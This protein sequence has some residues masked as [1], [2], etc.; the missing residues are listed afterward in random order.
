MTGSEVVAEVGIASGSNLG[1][2]GPETTVVVVASDLE[3]EAPIWW[4]RTKGASDRGAK[5]IVLNARSTKLDN[6][7]ACT[8]Q[9]EYGDAVGAVNNLLGALKSAKALDDDFGKNR[10]EG[11]NDV[12]GAKYGTIPAPFKE[13][14]EILA[15]TENLIVFVGAEGME[16][17]EH[18]DLMQAAGNLL[19]ATGRV[20]R[21]NNGLIPVWPGANTQG[22]LDMGFRAE[23]TAQALKQKVVI[24]AGADIDPADLQDAEFVIAVSLFPSATTEAADVVLPRQ[25]VPERRTAAKGRDSEQDLF[26][27]EN[28]LGR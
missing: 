5:I 19:G 10:S 8:L 26:L 15:G 4:L 22:A 6:Y 25:S 24:T 9:Y 20:G 1:N 7:A 12:K 16:L 18:A 21:P 17:A 23:A 14:A 27:R 28:F 11:Y 2:I 13:A 3:E